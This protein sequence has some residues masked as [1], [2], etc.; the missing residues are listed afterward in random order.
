MMTTIGVIVEK[1]PGAA[2]EPYVEDPEEHRRCIK[3]LFNLIGKLA[4]WEI[5]EQTEEKRR[6]KDGTEKI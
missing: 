5:T 3:S 2:K 6:I 4:P 1:G